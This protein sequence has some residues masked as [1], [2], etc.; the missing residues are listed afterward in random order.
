M[1]ETQFVEDWLLLDE[2]K[3]NEASRFIHKLRAR[4]KHKI[5]LRN[6]IC[7]LPTGEDTYVYFIKSGS[8]IK[9]GLSKDV[10]FRLTTMQTGNPVELELILKVGFKDSKSAYIAESAW[11]DFYS[12]YHHRGEWFN[13]TEEEIEVIQEVYFP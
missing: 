3:E 13:L 12:E 11:H 4:S 1:I 9:I 5:E 2:P 6:K 7:N 10:D 8:Y